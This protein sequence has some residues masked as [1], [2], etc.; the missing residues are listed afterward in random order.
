MGL[1]KFENLKKKSKLGKPLLHKKIHVVDL[2]VSLGKT[3]V[4]TCYFTEKKNPRKQTMDLK[5]GAIAQLLAI[6]L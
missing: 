5:N 4:K 3:P 2:Q 6:A 1:V